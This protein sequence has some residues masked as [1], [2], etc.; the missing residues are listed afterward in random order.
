M[1]TK[2]KFPGIDENNNFY[3]NCERKILKDKRLKFSHKILAL[4]ILFNS[5]FGKYKKCIISNSGFAEKYDLSPNHIS[6]CISE[7]NKMDVIKTWYSDLG[8]RQIRINKDY[9]YNNSII[10]DDN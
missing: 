3:F 8:Y 5:Y 6:K 2:E 10:N 4:D 7:L 9:F 1:K